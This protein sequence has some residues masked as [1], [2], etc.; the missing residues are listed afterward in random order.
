MSGRSR[1]LRFA[2]S[3]LA[4]AAAVATASCERTADASAVVGD[5]V[6]A[7]TVPGVLRIETDA[8]VDNLNPLLGQESIDTDIS[9]FWAG[10]LFNWTDDKKLLPELATEVPTVGNG[11]ISRDGRTIVYHLRRG[12]TWQDGEPFD[13]DDVVFTWR[14]IMNPR[15][16]VAVRQG[17]DLVERIETPDH[18]T[19]V[20]HLRKPYAPFVATFFAMSNTSYPVLPKHLLGRYPSI[21]TV[22]YNHLPVGTGP[23]RVVAHDAHGLKLVANRNYWRGVPLL[24][25]VYIR[26]QHDDTKILADLRSHTIDLYYNAY[27]QEEPR[28]HGIQGTT[29]YLYPFDGFTDVGFNLRSAVVA[30]TR[31]RQALAYG[32]DRGE[33]LNRIG[34]GVNVASDSDQA[35]FSAWHD[36]TV[37]HYAYDPARARAMLAAAGWTVGPSG[38]REKGG[39][40]L[41]IRLVGTNDSA[42]EHLIAAD[43]RALGVEVAIRNYDVATVDAPANRGGIEATGKFDAILE[44]WNNGVDPDDSEQF[45]CDAQP[46]A[47]WNAY[48][49]CNTAVDAAERA[50]LASN[51]P[52]VRRRAYDAVQHALA[53]DLPVIVL[54]F[55][56]QEDVANLDLKNYYPASAVTPFWNTWQLEI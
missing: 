28:L 7:W 29:I 20:V 44:G 30:D 22:A 12:V 42:T 36:G 13:A 34:N 47:G 21:D 4:L 24:S 43:W 55:N 53:E 41:R 18:Y 16:D 5:R 15:N 52:S 26:F 49:Y 54:Y 40:P 25:E 46:P 51:D 35:P 8:S 11:G 48:R 56:Q 39:R 17:Y 33:L 23:F 14:A 27:E 19:L 38:V 6:N 32:I 2:W 10:H 37:R 1:G 31:V 9:M 50:A 3:A 45:M